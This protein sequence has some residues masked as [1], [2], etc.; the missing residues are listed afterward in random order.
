ML[1]LSLGLGPI[2][3]A[4]LDHKAALPGVV[5]EPGAVAM[6][7]VAIGI[8]LE[9][10]GLHIVV[11]DAPGH[12]A[13]RRE[14][15]L[16]A[17]DQRIDLHVADELHIA[18]PT[19]TERGAERMQRRTAFAELDPVHLQLLAHRRLEA[20]HQVG[21]RLRSQRAHKGAQLA[22]AALIAAFGNLPMQHR[23]GNHVGMRGLLALT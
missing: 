3:L 1:D 20:H 2:R 15:A 19:R 8:A 6:L 11:Q 9:D 10:N 14:G 16:V 23:R 4:K 22:H 5:E 18:G 7:A 13:K 21:G 17:S 12:A